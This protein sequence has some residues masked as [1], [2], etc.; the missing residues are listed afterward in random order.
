M[1]EH[2]IRVNAIAPAAVR[3]GIAHLSDGA[4]HAVSSSVSFI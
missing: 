2:R 3:T 4:G 1:A